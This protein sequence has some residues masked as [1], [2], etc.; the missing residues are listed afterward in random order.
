[1]RLARLKCLAGCITLAIPVLIFCSTHFILTAHPKVKLFMTHGGLLSTQEAIYTG[2]PIV[3]IPIFGDQRMNVLRAVKGGYG[4][5]LSIKNITRS[6]ILKAIEA[7]LHDERFLFYYYHGKKKHRKY[8]RIM[9]EVRI[10]QQVFLD[11]P[12]TP[13]DR[14]VYWTEY[15]IRHS[16]ALHIRSAALDLTWYQVK[17]LDV[18]FFLTVLVICTLSIVTII[19]KLMLRNSDVRLKTE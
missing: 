13:L 4:V 9:L 7:G 8:F 3:G 10:R 11:Q 2:V 19:I 18:Y 14:A 6:S 15:I 1:M 17:L 5:M 16:G 12:Q